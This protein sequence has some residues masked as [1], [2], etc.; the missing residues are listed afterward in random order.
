[1]GSLLNQRSKKDFPQPL[2]RRGEPNGIYFEKETANETFKGESLM[3][4]I[5]GKKQLT[6]FPKEG[7]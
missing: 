2:R 5:S 3:G 1:M 4:Y 7:A 6:K